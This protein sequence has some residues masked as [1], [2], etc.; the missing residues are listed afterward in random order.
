MKYL[1]LMLTLFGISSQN[2]LQ[3]HYNTKHPGEGAYLFPLISSMAALLFFVVSAKFKFEFNSAVIPYSIGFAVSYALSVVTLLAALK[4]GPM[5]ITILILAYSLIIPA[6]HGMI[7]YND[8]LSTMGIIGLVL[9]AI[10]LYLINK[11]EKDGKINIKWLIYLTL[12][13]FGNGFCS[14]FQ[15]MEQVAFDGAYKNEFMI[16]ALVFVVISLL[17]LLFVT[18]EKSKLKNAIVPAAGCG[19][20][21][22]MVNLFVMILTAAFPSVIL[23]PTIAAGGI[24]IGYVVAVTIY[25]EKLTTCQLVGYVLGTVSVVLLNI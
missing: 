24:V 5:S 15:K 4:T 1:L 16:M 8:T 3:K 10:S 20:F 19:V 14:V 21:N 2:V 9:L 25:K 17:V 7:A 18:K 23:F 11:K 6:F 13:F 12:C 22:G